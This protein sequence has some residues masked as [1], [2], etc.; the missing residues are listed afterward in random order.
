M[1]NPY[2]LVTNNQNQKLK[3]FSDDG[4]RWFLAIWV[5]SLMLLSLI[6]FGLTGNTAVLL[7]TTTIGVPTTIVYRYFFEKKE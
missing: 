4:L 5:A 7:A 3:F 2:P 1:D 6:I